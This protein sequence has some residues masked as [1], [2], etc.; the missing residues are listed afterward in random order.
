MNEFTEKHHAFIAAS[1]YDVLTDRFGERGKQAFIMATRRYAEQRGSRMAQRAVRDGR[2]LDFATYCEYGEWV[3]TQTVKDLGC[4][5]KSHIES[6]SPDYVTHITCCP[7]ATQFA[8]MDLKD[9][10]VVY[11]T[12]LDPSIVRGFNPELTFITEQSLHDHDFCIQRVVNAGLSEGFKAQKKMEY[13]KGFD[14]HCGHNY[15]TYSEISGAVFG[16]EGKAAAEEVL[17]RFEKK[18]G[19]EMTDVLLSYLDT[20]FNLIL[21]V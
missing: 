3:N 10:G 18:Y 4:S 12:Y 15:K 7:W 9:G 8:E 16:E 6:Y 13:V 5:N 14:Y 19:R 1:F 2:K 20:D 21:K 17:K 11:C